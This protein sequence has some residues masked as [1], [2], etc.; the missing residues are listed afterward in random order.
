V[1]P[2]SYIYEIPLFSDVTPELCPMVAKWDGTKPL[3]EGVP[4]QC[5]CGPHKRDV[6]CPFGFWGYRYTIEQLSSADKPVTRIPATANCD[7]V[8]GETQFDVDLKSLAG[9]VERLRATLA[10]MPLAAQLREGKDKVSLQTLLGADLPF[11][12][13]YCHGQRQNVADPNT[14]LGVGKRETI[15]TG[16][17]IS[18]TGE[19]YD[20]LK[21]QIWDSVRPLVFI[22]ACHSVAIEP[23]TLV[24]Y[25]D[26]FVGRGCASGVIGTEVKVE[27]NMAMNVAESFVAAWMS[28]GS[29]VEEALRAIRFDYL[30]QGNLF[31]L[32]Y[33]P[34]CW[35]ELKIVR[36]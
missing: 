30:K 36:H 11:V 16:D 31:G 17:F 24:S 1:L 32:V 19:W 33:T 15:T 20:N 18:W 28:G 27:Q 29:T 8:I 35:S 5:P 2:W 25:I 3:F 6:L 7:V 10:G 13:F 23:E 14:Y 34:Y 12:Y 26:A 4:R 22:N 21:R 9:H